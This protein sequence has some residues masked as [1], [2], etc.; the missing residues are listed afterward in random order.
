MLFFKS[1]DTIVQNSRIPF[2]I[3]ILRAGIRSTPFFR[4]FLLLLADSSVGANWKVQVLPV[5]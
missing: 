4:I 3:P 2:Y 5:L 1:N